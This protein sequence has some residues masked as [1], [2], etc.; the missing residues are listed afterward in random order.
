MVF[1]NVKAILYI[2][3]IMRKTINRR[4][5]AFDIDNFMYGLIFIFYVCY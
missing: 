5:A 2:A 3:S 4:N 1:T